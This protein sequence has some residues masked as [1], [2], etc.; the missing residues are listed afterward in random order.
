MEVGTKM[1]SWFLLIQSFVNCS[2]KYEMLHDKP[3]IMNIAFFYPVSLTSLLKATKSDIKYCSSISN[4]CIIA[5][6][7]VVFEEP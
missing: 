2:Q 5:V 4:D 1:K 3:Y 6:E 7:I